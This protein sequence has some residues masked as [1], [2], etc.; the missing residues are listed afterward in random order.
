MPHGFFLHDLGD[1]RN[2]VCSLTAAAIV[3]RRLAMRRRLGRSLTA[4]GVAS[5]G[6]LAAL[7]C[8]YGGEKWR[9]GR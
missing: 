3:H 5:G 4:V 2:Q 7:L 9:R 6:G 1:K 8:S